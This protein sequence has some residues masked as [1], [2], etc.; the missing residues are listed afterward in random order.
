MDDV[1]H[2]IRKIL[3]D[4]RT[5]KDHKTMSDT[6]NDELLL[7]QS[8]MIHPP[9]TEHLE[10][11]THKENEMDT[12]FIHD[13]HDSMMGKLTSDAVERSFNDLKGQ[14]AQASASA[15][16]KDMPISSQGSLTVEDIVRGEVRE[17]VRTWLDT[18]LPSMVED[19]V[20]AEIARLRPKV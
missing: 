12:S 8:M 15:I 2:T 19:M 17:M 7:D 13:D 3:H 16:P 4:D 20:R 10:P 9:A 14:F 1:L 6:V 11:A 5:S 18:H